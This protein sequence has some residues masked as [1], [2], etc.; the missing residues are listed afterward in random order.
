M[1]SQ[2]IEMFPVQEVTNLEMAFPATVL[3]LMPEWEAIPQEFK[4]FNSTKWNKLFNQWFYSG[5]DQGALPKAKEGI[6]R[7]KALRHIRTIMGSF[8]PKH[9][10]KEAAVAYLMSLWFEEQA[11]EI[12]NEP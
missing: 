6:D 4:R 2:S 8:E 12:T 7:T 3:H 9:E 10:H 1:K 5:I 11:N